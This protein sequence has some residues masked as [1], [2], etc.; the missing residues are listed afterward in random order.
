MS[1]KILIIVVITV[2]SVFYINGCKKRT[3]ELQS[4]TEVA[5]TAAEYESDAK[6]Q[7]NR[8][9]MAEELGR[10]EKALDKDISQE[11]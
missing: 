5:K 10:I 2:I 3:S 1:R 7:I 4:D 8:E 6:E 11:Q 9:N